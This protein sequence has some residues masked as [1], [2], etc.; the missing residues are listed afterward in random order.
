[1]NIFLESAEI[2]TYLEARGKI[3][4]A[5]QIH[6]T[7]D[8]GMKRAVALLLASGKRKP[9]WTIEDIQN[10]FNDEERMKK[11]FGEQYKFLSSSKES[12]IKKK[13]SAFA[14]LL[15]SSD[16]N[17]EDSLRVLLKQIFAPESGKSTLANEFS[18]ANL[19]QFGDIFERF[20]TL[21]Q[22]YTNTTIFKKYKLRFSDEHE[23]S[24]SAQISGLFKL[25]MTEAQN[26]FELII[27]AEDSGKNVIPDKKELKELYKFIKI[28]S[29]INILWPETSKEITD[30]SS[31]IKYINETIRYGTQ[32]KKQIEFYK[33]RRNEYQ[34]DI[35]QVLKYNDDVLLKIIND[36]IREFSDD[37]KALSKSDPIINDKLTEIANKL[38]LKHPGL[39]DYL[40]ITSSDPES[41]FI[42]L[43]AKRYKNPKAN[44]GRKK[45][46]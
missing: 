19:K 31:F 39:Y 9:K 32:A 7:F 10:E 16:K 41:E 44:V 38:F 18:A 46:V 37:N 4:K 14:A 5:K 2:F 45:K 6:Q 22:K 11:I 29:N 8:S 42:G 40:A 25:L 23:K 20:E 13:A 15:V 36:N 43:L 33:K 3:S 28:K 27:D 34:D 24:M 26:L 30:A 1:M 21:Y 35:Q 12:D 17:T